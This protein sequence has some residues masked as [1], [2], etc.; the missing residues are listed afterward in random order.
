M[1]YVDAIRDATDEDR[2]DLIDRVETNAQRLLDMVG[3]LVQFATERAAHSALL[4]D[5]INAV[6]VVRDAVHDIS[7]V[8]NPARVE[9]LGD[10]ALAK[11]NGV[12]L[13]RVVTNL[14]VNALKY[15]PPGARS[16][17]PSPTRASGRVHR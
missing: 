1:G 13:H 16:T 9:V 2:P 14:V 17:S 3:G 10:V 7:P 8:L 12:A 5:D 6:E 15:S 11:A 4:M